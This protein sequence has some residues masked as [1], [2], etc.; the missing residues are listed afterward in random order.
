MLESCA[1]ECLD[2]SRSPTPTEIQ[3]PSSDRACRVFRLATPSPDKPAVGGS[4]G[5]FRGLVRMSSAD[6]LST[7][8]GCLTRSTFAA[9]LIVRW[10][11]VLSLTR[12]LHRQC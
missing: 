3:R 2:Q 8:V 12:R 11:R 7:S 6:T 9:L 1:I 5:E 4:T 10:P